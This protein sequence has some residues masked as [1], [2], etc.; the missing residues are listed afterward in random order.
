VERGEVALAGAP[1]RPFLEQFRAGQGHDVDGGI[2]RPL[3]EVVDEVE[4]A[5]IGEVV[6]LED[7][8]HRG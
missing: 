8:D 1:G 4:Q 2:A 3:E 7:E 6:V 5:R